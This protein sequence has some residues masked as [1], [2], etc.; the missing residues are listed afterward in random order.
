MDKLDKKILDI[1]QKE[2]PIEPR[3]FK[4][5][6]EQVGTS[7]ADVISRIKKLK[8]NRIIRRVGGSFDSKG[9]GYHSVLVAAK[10]SD[11]KLKNTV[12]CLNRYTGVT[13]NY[14]RNHD[15]NLWFTLTASSPKRVNEIIEILKQETGAQEMVPLPSLR[16]FK[17]KVHFKMSEE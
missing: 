14:Q 15:Y 12:S 11:E 4:V 7:E 17:I 8:Q 6:A 10:V 13:H 3:A 16:K 5:V 1:I 2:I 9:L